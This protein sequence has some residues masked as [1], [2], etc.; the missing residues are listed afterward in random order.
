MRKNWFHF[1][2]ISRLYYES[3]SQKAKACSRYLT[4]TKGRPQK[5]YVLSEHG[6]LYELK[7]IIARKEAKT[8]TQPK[9][10]I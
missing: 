5:D 2:A 8:K 3:Q 1:K 4:K 7:S 10:F 6:K 9:Q